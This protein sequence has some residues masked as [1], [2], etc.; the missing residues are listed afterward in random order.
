MYK[1]TPYFTGIQRRT[2]LN[3]ITQKSF[4]EISIAELAKAALVDRST[5]YAHFDSLFDLAK[6]IVDKALIPFEN[7]FS[8]AKNEHQTNLQF[9]SYN[10]FSTQLVNVVIQDSQRL[11]QIRQLQLGQNSFDAKLRQLF[12]QIYTTVLHVDQTDFTIYLFVSMAMANFEFI[13]DHQRIPS[14]QELAQGIRKMA[15]FLS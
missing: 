12:A 8:T 1:Y 6:N 10:F 7:A 3:L 11:R 15:T 4:S 9:D 2:F 14:K 5:F 13:A